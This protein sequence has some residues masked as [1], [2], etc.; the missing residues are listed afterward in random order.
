MSQVHN[1]L[2]TNGATDG[3]WT[4]DVGVRGVDRPVDGDGGGRVVGL[5]GLARCHGLSQ[6][7]GLGARAGL[8]NARGSVPALDL[9]QYP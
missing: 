4:L 9:C 8:L 6:C 5:D 3:G 1:C 2:V 7:Q